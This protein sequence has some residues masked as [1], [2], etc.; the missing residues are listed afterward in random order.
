MASDIMVAAALGRPFTLGMLYDARKD[1]LIPGFRLWD[2]K[3]LQ[4]KIGESLQH[5]STFEISVSDSIESKSSLLKVD[6]SLM[7]SFMSGL[8]EVEGSAEY[9][10]DKK[11]FKNQSR[12]TF[13]YKAT[14]HFKELSLTSLSTMDSQ[15]REI[16][17]NGLATHVVTGILYGAHAFFV[18]DSEKL[19]ASSVKDKQISMKAVIKKIPDFNVQGKGDIKLNEAEKALTKTFSCKFYGDFILE[20]NPATF[21]DAVKTYAQLPQLL[22]KNGENAVP[23]KV[24]LMPLKNLDSEAAELMNGISVGL[25]RRAQDTLEDLRDIGIR[26]ND[27]LEDSVVEKFQHIQEELSTFQKLCGNYTSKLQRTMAD[28][29]PSIREGKDDESSVE[30]LFEDRDK[31]LFNHETLSKWLN[32]KEREINVIRSCVD[33]MKEAKIILNQSELDREVLAP[34][35]EHVLCFVFTS[36]ESGDTS[37]NSLKLGSSDEDQWYSSDS[38]LIQMRKKAEAFRDVVKA[39]KKNCRFR[40]LVAAIKN[41]K[42]S[43]ATIYHYKDG[44]LDTEDFSRPDLPD[45]KTI[46]DR[47]D[48][49]WYSCDLTLDPNTANNY[50]ILSEGNKKATCGA[51]QTYPDHPER[52]SKY[53]QALCKEG[54][55]KRHYWE[56]E[57]STGSIESSYVAASYKRIERKGSGPESVLGSNT[58]SWTFGQYLSS[59]LRSLRAWHN[60]MVW[61]IPFPSS[62]CNVIG[63]FLDWPA[64]TMS[65]Y[66]VSSNTLSHLYTF[67]NT[68]TE[69]VYPGIWANKY[70]NYVHLRPLD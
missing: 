39:L 56:V 53:P 35:V 68:F 27:S 70:S 41:K 9:L 28:K 6:A 1:E 62:G 15:Q 45:V 47:S 40:F 59:K 51:W 32:C 26:C 33:T 65:F 18:F 11:K 4:E 42:Y 69:P 48:L 67:R 34:G 14:T 16:I 60:G 19:E 30:Q 46:T 5:S 57:L 50:I 22:G 10:N 64:G 66:K 37:L 7:A 25:V 54:L 20:S 55:Y 31:S 44:I 17:K 8:F 36:M 12:V 2:G 49:I 63:V 43:G 24:W 23:V 52:F 58:I 61:E 3:A 21:E 13:Q 38:V 29:L